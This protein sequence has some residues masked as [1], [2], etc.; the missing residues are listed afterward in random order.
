M[1]WLNH[2]FGNPDGI[3][4]RP[5]PLAAVQTRGVPYAERNKRVGPAGIVLAALAGADQDTVT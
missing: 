3:C 4:F 2:I 5:L 1:R